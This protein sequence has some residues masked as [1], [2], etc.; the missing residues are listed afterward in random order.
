MPTGEKREFGVGTPRG[1]RA[2]QGWAGCLSPKV[3]D[4]KSASCTLGHCPDS[5]F[6][7]W[8]VWSEGW[9]GIERAHPVE[10]EKK[11]LS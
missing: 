10:E 11:I 5:R 4:K 7:T 2:E 1:G 6:T 3:K 8:G 9:E